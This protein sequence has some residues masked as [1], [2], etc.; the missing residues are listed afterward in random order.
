MVCSIQVRHFMLLYLIYQWKAEDSLITH[1]TLLQ[2]SACIVI[3]V[4]E[5]RSLRFA[6]E[7]MFAKGHVTNMHGHGFKEMERRRLC[8]LF[9]RAVRHTSLAKLLRT[10]NCT[11]IPKNNTTFFFTYLHGSEPLLKN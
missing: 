3:L 5:G 6:W 8:C 10:Y 11:G 2:L 9:V 7:K 4:C 1:S